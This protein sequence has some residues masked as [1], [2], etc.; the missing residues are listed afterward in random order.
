MQNAIKHSNETEFTNTSTL[1]DKGAILRYLKEHKIDVASYVFA[2]I[3]GGAVIMKPTS[4]QPE[5]VH[6][7]IQNTIQK[8]SLQ[9]NNIIEQKS[10][11]I[12]DEFQRID[13]Q[14]PKK[15][16]DIERE[17]PLE[18]S[19]NFQYNSSITNAGEWDYDQNTWI[20]YIRLNPQMISKI[21]SEK[22]TDKDLYTENLY[23]N[24]LWSI[25]FMSKY[26]HQDLMQDHDDLLQKYDYY[27]VAEMLGEYGSLGNLEAKWTNEANHLFLLRIKEIIHSTWSKNQY[28]MVSDI[29]R[30][31]FESVFMSSND[32]L[33]YTNNGIDQLLTQ[34]YYGDLPYSQISE[35]LY[36]IKDNLSSQW[37]YV[38]DIL[39]QWNIST[40]IANNSDYTHN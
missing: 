5:P 4:E 12:S 28:A 6:S 31:S 35:F 27:Q 15:N 38:D 3:L 10:A 39:K 2:A 17:T 33:S 21:S 16:D 30:A 24:E 34:N 19:I 13:Q 32:E 14:T 9:I 23:Y 25:Q 20:G 8:Q 11:S 37:L 40:K 36:H 26:S 7:G 1:F 22:W 18:L 29:F